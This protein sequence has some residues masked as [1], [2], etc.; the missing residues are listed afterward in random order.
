MYYV[1][2]QVHITMFLQTPAASAATMAIPGSMTQIQQA[3]TSHGKMHFTT[4]Q[5]YQ[6]LLKSL[7]V[8]IFCSD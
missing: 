6:F 5:I 7:V 4:V 8:I 3:A 1:L 2:G